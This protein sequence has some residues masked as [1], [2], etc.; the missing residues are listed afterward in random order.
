MN[1]RAVF[2]M[3]LAIILLVSCVCGKEAGQK[4]CEGNA[5]DPLQEIVCDP[6]TGRCVP[7]GGSGEL[8]CLNAGCDSKHVC[9]EG[10]VCQP[11][12]EVEQICCGYVPR[13]RGEYVRCS[14]GMCELPVEAILLPAAGELC[15]RATRSVGGLTPPAPALLYVI[16]TVD[17]GDGWD[18]LRLNTFPHRPDLATDLNTVVCITESLIATASY[19]DGTS[20][21]RRDWSVQLVS[22]PDG[23]V[24]AEGEFKGIGPPS[25]VLETGED[26]ITKQPRDAFLE[27]LNE[28]MRTG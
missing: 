20:A 17:E 10:G 12:G 7:C 19:T 18:L 13:C 5:C 28:I 24:L 14:Q 21:F 23:T 11:C 16:N 22:H 1:V 27:W 3:A 4:C 25:M 15:D 9:N 2:T 6:E 8:C 26:I